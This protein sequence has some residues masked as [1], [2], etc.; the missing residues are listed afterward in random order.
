[1][2]K[3]SFGLKEGKFLFISC[4]GK[5]QEEGGLIHRIRSEN[6]AGNEEPRGKAEKWED[7][8]RS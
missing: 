6:H 8:Q 1:M 2:R 5:R 7:Q 3:T 4:L